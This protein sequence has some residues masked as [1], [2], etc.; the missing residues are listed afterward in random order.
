MVMKTDFYV[1]EVFAFEDIITLLGC[2][3]DDVPLV[4][5]EFPRQIAPFPEHKI[6]IGLPL[7]DENDVGITKIGDLVRH[8]KKRHLLADPDSDYF[9]V[10][11][12]KHGVVNDK[13]RFSVTNG[14]YKAFHA[15]MD[16]FIFSTSPFVVMGTYV[17]VG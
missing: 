1:M 14:G 3:K 6:G 16:S 4:I 7:S 9:A 17:I 12:K 8:R 2:A 11:R 10:K 5:A 13:S 15:T